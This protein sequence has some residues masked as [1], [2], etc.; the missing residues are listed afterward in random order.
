MA[1]LRQAFGQRDDKS[2]QLMLEIE[3]S[4]HESCASSKSTSSTEVPDDISEDSVCSE[5]QCHRDS[6]ERTKMETKLDGGKLP[7]IR[8]NYTLKY[9]Y[10]EGYKLPVLKQKCNLKYRYLDD[11]GCLDH[12]DP[13]PVRRTTR[14]AG[15]LVGKICGPNRDEFDDDDIVSVN[16]PCKDAHMKA[17]R[18]PEHIASL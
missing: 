17:K 8:W 11:E 4:D 2:M 10:V 6:F 1:I 18:V 3:P 12:D 15:P 5:S 14:H 7:N 16:W 13:W 9:R